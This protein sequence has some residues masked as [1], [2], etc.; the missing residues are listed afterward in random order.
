M[1]NSMTLRRLGLA[2]AATTIAGTF[3][4][5]MLAPANAFS[6]KGVNVEDNEGQEGN[7][8][9]GEDEHGGQQMACK[10]DSQDCEAGGDAE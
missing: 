3:A 4:F 2:I 7:G 5:S 1:K 9:S 10:Q 6:V 8:I